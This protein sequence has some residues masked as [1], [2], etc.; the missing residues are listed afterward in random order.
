MLF[1]A[2]APVQPRNLEEYWNRVK[3]REWAE[4]LS[5]FRLFAG[6]P[7]RKLRKLIARARIVDYVPGETVL[8]QG[9]PGDSLYVILSGSAKA[10]GK[11]AARVLGVGDYFGELS[12][13]D[14]APRSAAVVATSEL[15][16]MRIER[17]AFLRLAQRYPVMSLKMAGNLGS[18]VRRLEARLAQ[19]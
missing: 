19:P 2:F 13:L 17:A 1:G 15:Q 16:V 8:E 6:I 18:Q 4:I 12:I 3:P 5:Q 9:T 11:P 10:R 7:R 14:E